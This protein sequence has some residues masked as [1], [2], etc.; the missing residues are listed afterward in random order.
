MRNCADDQKLSAEELASL[1]Q[2]INADE[3]TK[4]IEAIID[5]KIRAGLNGNVLVA[6]KGIVLY[7]RCNGFG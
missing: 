7:K 5:E 6:Q 3:K 4:R 1:R 2:S